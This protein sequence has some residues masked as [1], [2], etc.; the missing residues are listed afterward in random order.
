MPAFIVR[1]DTR[2]RFVFGQRLREATPP[3][4]VRVCFVLARM[5]TGCSRGWR[6]GPRDPSVSF[7]HKCTYSVFLNETETV[8]SIVVKKVDGI[9]DNGRP[10]S[11]ISYL[12]II[13]YSYKVLVLVN[14]A[15][16]VLC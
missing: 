11:S 9:Q 3:I 7:T 15:P 4:H 10:Q 5:H 16:Q 1:F 6:G 14:A 2:S 8:R 12:C 13:A